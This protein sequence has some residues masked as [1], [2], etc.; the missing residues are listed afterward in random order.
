M[1][2]AYGVAQ[3]KRE[4]LVEAVQLNLDWLYTIIRSEADRGNLGF[5]EYWSQGAARFERA[6]KWYEANH[7]VLVRTLTAPSPDAR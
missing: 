7:E 4:Q 5:V 6:R 3:A 1:V 2:D